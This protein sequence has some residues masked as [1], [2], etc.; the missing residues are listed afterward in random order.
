[1]HPGANDD[2]LS[3][4][5]S[6]YDNDSFKKLLYAAGKSDKDVK[7]LMDDWKKLTKNG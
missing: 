7:S 4:L 2:E 1:M 6:S 3:I 5:R